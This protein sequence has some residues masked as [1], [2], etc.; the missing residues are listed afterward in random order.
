MV[1]NFNKFQN[2][3][4]RSKN[5]FFPQFCF[6]FKKRH[7]ERVRKLLPPKVSPYS[8]WE[9]CKPKEKKKKNFWGS[10]KHCFI[11][12]NASKNCFF[13]DAKMSGEKRKREEEEKVK[14]RETKVTQAKKKRKKEEKAP[15]Y[16]LSEEEKELAEKFKEWREER[17]KEGERKQENSF[18]ETFVHFEKECERLLPLS[19][20]PSLSPSSSSSSSSSSSPFLPEMVEGE[21]GESSVGHVAG[22]EETEKEFQLLKFY[23]F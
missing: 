8:G 21:G 19:S 1:T 22:Q 20:L 18:L 23:F 2:S 7:I 17:A 9:L 16:I 10:K 4:R 3:S 11:L 6:V 15:E 14:E 5:F 13:F 12:S